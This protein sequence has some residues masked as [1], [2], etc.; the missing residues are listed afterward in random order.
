MSVSHVEVIVEEP[1]A[2]AAMQR[3]LPRILGDAATF[4][5]YAHSCK[6]ELLKRLPDRLRGYA[7]WL[8]PDWRVVVLIDRDDEDCRKLKRRLESIAHAASLSTRA[9]GKPIQVVNRV[10]IEELEAWFFGDWQAVRSAYP[11]VNASVPQQ[12][13]YRAP[14]AIRGGTWEA[15]ERLLQAAGYFSTGL[16]KIEAARA[17]ADHM[18]PDRNVSPSFRALHAA[19]TQMVQP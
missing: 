15:L 4:A 6:D 7:S 10:A 8:P 5:I 2:E 12:A 9:S 19:L 1:S 16:R 11:R 3:L 18:V 14:D 17:V 13:K